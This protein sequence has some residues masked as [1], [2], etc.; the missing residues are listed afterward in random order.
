MHFMTIRRFSMYIEVAR[1]LQGVDIIGMSSTS[2]NSV[3][4]AI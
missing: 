4:V 2:V 1:G 3:L